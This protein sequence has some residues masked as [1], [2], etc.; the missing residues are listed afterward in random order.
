VSYKPAF[1]KGLTF[2]ADVFNVFNRQTVQAINEV[3]EV[4]DD[5]RTI[6]PTYGRTIAYTAPRSVKLTVSYDVKF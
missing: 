1:A 4:N 3:H 5:P 2:R 6:T